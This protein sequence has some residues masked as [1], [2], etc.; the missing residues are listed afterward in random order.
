MLPLNTRKSSLKFPKKKSQNHK[1]EGR[2]KNVG[3]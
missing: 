2:V 1:L 3:N